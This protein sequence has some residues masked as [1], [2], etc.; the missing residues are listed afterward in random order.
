MRMKLKFNGLVFT[1]LLLSISSYGQYLAGYP[2][3]IN[4]LDLGNT[5]VT[6]ANVESSF[7]VPQKYYLED[8]TDEGLGIDEYYDYTLDGKRLHMKFTDGVIQEFYTDS[9]DYLIFG[10]I[11]VGGNIQDLRDMQANG[12]GRF[13]MEEVKDTGYRT[14]VIKLGDDTLR[15]TH[16]DNI[17]EIIWYQSVF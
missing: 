17:I 11:R 10:N 13:Y 6:K 5:P 14:T 12:F 3:T 9:P 15:V 7:G 4:G 8:A 2:D 1:L 16:K